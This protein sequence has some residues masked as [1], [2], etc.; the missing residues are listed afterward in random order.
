MKGPYLSVDSSRRQTSV[1]SDISSRIFRIFGPVDRPR[2][3]RYFRYVTQ[4]D[5]SV[6]RIWFFTAAVLRHDGWTRQNTGERGPSNEMEVL[7]AKREATRTMYFT[8]FE[9]RIGAA[10]TDPLRGAGVSSH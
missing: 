9:G 1:L 2:R 4:S 5:R 6:A 3:R 10:V 8:S 7:H